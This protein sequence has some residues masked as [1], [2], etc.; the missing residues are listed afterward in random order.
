M[1]MPNDTRYFGDPPV[2]PLDPPEPVAD[3]EISDPLTEAQ[4]K[5]LDEAREAA[6]RRMREEG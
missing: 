5:E 3:E 4:Q 6:L 1:Y 2:P